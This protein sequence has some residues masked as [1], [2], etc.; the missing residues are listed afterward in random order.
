MHGNS[1][2]EVR[3]SETRIKS[4]KEYLNNHKEIIGFNNKIIQS[5]E[6]NYNMKSDICLLI[7]GSITMVL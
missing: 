2:S 4:F 3:E 6:N 5:D 7:H 1:Q